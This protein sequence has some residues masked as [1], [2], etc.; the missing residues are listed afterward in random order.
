MNTA[1]LHPMV[2]HFPI[3]LIITGFAL[4]TLWIILRK[5]PYSLTMPTVLWGLGTIA[6]AV[7]VVFGLTFTP[8]M[9]GIMGEIRSTHILMAGIT[10]AIS[11]IGCV[12]LCVYAFSQNKSKAL[13][14]ISYVLY[15]AAA[16]VIGFTGHL[17]GQMVFG[18]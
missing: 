12:L 6:L 10:L 4:M 7:A 9:V 5:K 16:V 13:L 17:G 15:V 2:V 14:V 3:A 11:I 8:P 18:I 1:L